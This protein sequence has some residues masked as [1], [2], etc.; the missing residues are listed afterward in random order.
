LLRSDLSFLDSA[1]GSRADVRRDYPALVHAHAARADRIVVSSR[2]AAYEVASRLGVPP[3]KIAL[4]P[5]GAGMSPRQASPK[6]GYVLFMGTIDRARTSACRSTHERLLPDRLRQGLAVRSRAPEI[7]TALPDLVLAGKATPAA[8]MV[9]PPEH[10]PLRGVCPPRLRRRR[11]PAA[12]Y[13]TARL[14]VRRHD[15]G[16]GLPVL[17]PW[18]RVRSSAAALPEVVGGAGLIDPSPGGRRCH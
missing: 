11:A 4:C 7:E 2:Y 9:G 17:E 18:R 6:P 5:P 1:D 10:L 3:S 13:E 14:L 16:F 12:A 15:E 8:R